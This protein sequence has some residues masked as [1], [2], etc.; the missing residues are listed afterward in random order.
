MLG[1]VPGVPKAAELKTTRIVYELNF[2]ASWWFIGYTLDQRTCGFGF[3]SVSRFWAWSV[4]W[5]RRELVKTAILRCIQD[6]GI[7]GSS[8]GIKR[9]DL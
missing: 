7:Q 1:D 9:L 6:L 3:D 2:K 5:S 4:I 8:E